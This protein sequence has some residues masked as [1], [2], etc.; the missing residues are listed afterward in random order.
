[1]NCRRRIGSGTQRG[2][3][4]VASLLLLLVVT[5]MAIS[6]FRGSGMQ[7]RIAG[8]VREKQRALQAAESAQ[9]Y[10]EWWLANNG[11][12]AT[13]PVTCTG[14]LS[15]NANQGQIC[16]NTLPVVTGSAANVVNV[17][18]QVN[19]ADVGVTFTPPGMTV[20][21]AAPTAAGANNYAVTPRFY[22]SDMGLSKD[23]TIPGEIFQID[24][25][26]YGGT[27]NTVAVV[28]STYAVYVKSRQL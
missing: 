23:V 16:I 4:L 9:E 1:M 22:I 3:V 10:A 12:A 27:G 21:A 18:W 25:V 28:E 14:L 6:M 2:M 17:P 24:A 20:A 11:N 5:I 7:E 13:T 19:N 15:A 26:G 8:N